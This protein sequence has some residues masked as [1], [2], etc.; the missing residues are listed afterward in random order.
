MKKRHDN[1]TYQR[2]LDAASEQFGTRGYKAVTLRDIGNALGMEH[3]SLYYYAPGGKKQLYLDV[4]ERSFLRH[5]EGIEAAIAQA[6][7]DV[8][9]QLKAVGRWLV[10]Q[11]PMDMKGVIH[12]SSVEIGE[13]QSAR[14]SQLAYNALRQPLVKALAAARKREEISQRN[15]DMAALAFVTLIEVVHGIPVR[16]NAAQMDAYIDEVIEMLLMGWVGR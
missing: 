11:P 6:G 16:M 13:E 15:L 1:E 4:M 3:A 12:T 8:R 7:E 2:L 9:A 14:L 10:S 5:Q